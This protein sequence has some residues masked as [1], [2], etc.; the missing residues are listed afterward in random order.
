M[1]NIGFLEISGMDL[2]GAIRVDQPSSFHHHRDTNGNCRGVLLLL[3]AVACH[4]QLHTFWIECVNV[5]EPLPWP[6]VFPTL[7]NLA[8]RYRLQEVRQASPGPLRQAARKRQRLEQRFPA[9][10]HLA[11]AITC[12]QHEAANV[13]GDWLPIGPDACMYNSMMAVT[14]EL[15]DVGIMTIAEESR[16]WRVLAGGEPAVRELVLPL[17]IPASTRTTCSA[18]RSRH[19]LLPGR[20]VTR[21]CPVADAYTCIVKGHCISCHS[22]LLVSPILQALC[23]QQPRGTALTI[24]DVQDLSTTRQA[25]ASW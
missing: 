6:K 13:T 3:T 12:D 25:C 14:I 2:N 8:V 15:S 20:F 4:P 18:G 16:L 22:L 24:V 17:M 7:T 1:H 5:L 11:F 19:P 9:L 23:N 10:R 21:S